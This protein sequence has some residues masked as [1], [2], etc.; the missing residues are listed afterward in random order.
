V[1]EA[2][3]LVP[4]CR[5]C[6]QLVLV[7]DQCQL[8]PTV[9]S[10]RAVNV[11]FAEPL[12]NRLVSLGVEPLLLDTQYRMHPAISQFP[13]DFF[14]GGRICDG[15]EASDRPAPAG[16]RWPR[17]D[18]P[19][20]FVPMRRGREVVEGVSRYNAAEADEVAHVV[21]GFLAAGMHPGAIG[22][23]TP[24]AAQVR[25]IRRMF[26]RPAAGDRGVEVSSV[27]GFQG[28]EKDVIVISTVRASTS[29]GVGFLADWR[30]VNV[31]FTRPRN[32]LVVIGH[33]DTL[34]RDLETWGRWLHWVSAHGVNIDEPYARGHLDRAALRAA[35]PSRRILPGPMPASELS[36]QVTYTQAHHA[37]PEQR[38]NPR[39]ETPA[40][41]PPHP[42]H[43][44]KHAPPPPMHPPHPPAHVPPPPTPLPPPPTHLP[45]THVP[46]PPTYQPPAAQPLPPAPMHLPPAPIHAAPAHIAEAPG[47]HQHQ[48]QHA[49]SVHA[50]GAP[51]A[52]ML[53][54]AQAQM[55]ALQRCAEEATTKTVGEGAGGEEGRRKR[56]GRWAVA[57]EQAALERSWLQGRKPDLATYGDGGGPS[58]RMCS[59]HPPLDGYP[60]EH[61]HGDPH[62]DSFTA[63]QMAEERHAVQQLG[64]GAETGADA[65]G[66]GASEPSSKAAGPTLGAFGWMRKGA[67]Q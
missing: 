4:L 60:Q 54:G 45:Q 64:A 22:V 11:G 20:A 40:P 55:H 52:G 48:H 37:F 8:P 46:P 5:G 61:S 2:S 31:A 57:E 49:S 53:T 41:L 30:R 39:R 56:K 35:A 1:T 13:A 59:S 33:P 26:P 12:F 32:G 51:A 18:W 28:R 17:S 16:F 19:V 63:A 10:Q 23:V 14:Y 36:E 29:G 25:V 9:S 66:S 21:K 3:S 42:T 7:G 44:A 67:T 47:A 24:Y 6:E 43:P 62:N 34:A 27:D 38:L 58:K 65:T 50:L 15:I